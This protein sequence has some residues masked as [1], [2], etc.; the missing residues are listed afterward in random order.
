[1]RSKKTNMEYNQSC[2]KNAHTHTYS[3]LGICTLPRSNTFKRT[4]TS[5]HAR[6]HARTHTRVPAPRS[7][8]LWVALRW[9]R[10]VRGYPEASWWLFPKPNPVSLRRLLLPRGDGQACLQASLRIW[11][12]W[13]N[14]W[15]DVWMNECGHCFLTVSVKLVFKLLYASKMNEWMDGWI[16]ALTAC[17]FNLSSSFFT[18]LN[19][20]VNDW[21]NEWMRDWMKECIKRPF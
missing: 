21:M 6:T 12:E 5:T 13:M 10:R 17:Q 2:R 18:H 1:M 15:M 11:N 7:W 9:R 8:W 19:A 16:N 3:N 20:W 4:H 14:E